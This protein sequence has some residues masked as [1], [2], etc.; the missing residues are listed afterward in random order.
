MEFLRKNKT[1]VAFVL[2]LVA[3]FI[4]TTGFSH[5]MDDALSKLSKTDVALVYLK[6]GFTHILPL[7]V[8]HILFVVSIFLLNPKLKS[9]IWQATAFTIAHSITLGLAMYQVITPPTHIIEPIIALSIMFVAIENI[10]TDKLKSARIF[11]IFIFGLIHGMGFAS[12]LTELGLPQ[13]Q[14]FTSLV[15]FNVGVELGQITVILI[16]WVLIGKW[17]APKEWYR[18]RI[19]VPMSVVIAMMG[20]YWTVGR[21]FFAS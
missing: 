14:F 10:I 15:T 6:L 19:V 1:A 12:A 18:A 11:I 20:L 3:L 16:T 9:V 2:M 21:T 7:G 13:N 17:F 5:P 8:D 4:P